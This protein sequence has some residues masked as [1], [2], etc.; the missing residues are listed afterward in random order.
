MSIRKIKRGK[1][2]KKFTYAQ[3]RKIMTAFNKAN[4]NSVELTGIIVFKESSYPVRY[5]EF[6]RS[7]IVSSYNKAFMPN[8]SSNSL[9]GCCLDGLDEGVRLD[10]YIGAEWEVDYCYFDNNDLPIVMQY[11]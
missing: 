5:T 2:M 9:F 10:W 7:Y 8:T 4:N 6:Q 3:F 11:I 1:T